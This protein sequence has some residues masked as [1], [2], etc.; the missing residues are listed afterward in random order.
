MSDKDR[1]VVV[2]IDSLGHED[3]NGD[4]N[5]LDHMPFV[6]ENF[7]IGRMNAHPV[8]VTPVVL[9]SVYTGLK[10]TDHGMPSISRYNQNARLR[11][12]GQMLPE[13]AAADPQFENVAQLW[14]PFM[15][16]PNVE[17]EDGYWHASEAM[18]QNS[19]YPPQAQNI[20]T[21]YAPAGRIDRDDENHD[22]A[23]NL[24]VD[25]CQSTFGTARNLLEQWDLDVMFLGYRVTDSYVHYLYDDPMGE[26]K[27]YRQRILEQVDRE[28]EYL[29]DQA[30]V[31]IF[32]D[33][34]GRDL[35]EIFKI[36]RWLMDH[37]Y[38]D[39]TI[40]RDFREKAI[41]NGLMDEPD[42]PGEVLQAGMPGVTINES[43]SVAINDDPFS[44]GLTL[45]DGATESNVKQLIDE[46]GDNP[47]IE[48]VAKTE[49]VYGQGK[50]LNECPELYAVRAPGVFVSGNLSPKLGGVEVTRAGV[51][52]PVGAYGAQ[53][54]FEPRDGEI[55]PWDLFDVISEW[56]GLDTMDTSKE[57]TSAPEVD[58]MAVKENLRDLGYL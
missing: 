17:D 48:E 42:Q 52:H 4:Y 44:T 54:D 28:I 9:G 29:A 35:T 24:R 15:V 41:L 39:V 46:L 7:N 45:L 18:G 50:H 31:F 33:H 55:K 10:P 32:G 57:S 38:L 30:E 16:P 12:D 23:F 49:E 22:L 11:P 6:R 40:D 2:F 1:K 51:H 13:I 26:E 56:L 3:P 14:Y 8:F 21:H 20:L 25:H 27:T 47:A 34:G 37:D 58:E 19:F 5:D 53:G 36:N 43:G